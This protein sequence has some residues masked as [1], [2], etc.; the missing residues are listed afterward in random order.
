MI[1]IGLLGFGTV[2][3]GFYDIINKK[4]SDIPSIIGDDLEVVK[5]LVR[6]LEKNRR[7]QI[8]KEK[9][10]LSFEELVNDPR[11]SIIVEVT[12][13]IE[14]SY[15][16]IKEALNNGKHV[17]T[18]NKGVVSAYFEELSSIALNKGLYFLY[19]ASV[20]GGIPVIKPIKDMVKLN[21]I[22]NVM[23]ILNG[24][25][26]YMLTKMTEESLSYNEV[27]NEA[28]SL[29]YAEEDPSSDVEGLDTLR[30]LRILSSIAF[31]GVITEDDIICDGIENI[32]DLD[33]KL[34][35]D[36][37]K[38][39]K[40][41][42]KTYRFKDGYCSIVQPK[43]VDR[44]SFF[45]NVNYAFNSI[46]IEGDNIGDIKFYGLGAGMYPSANAIF[47][48]CIDVV[49][50]N[51]TKDT[52]LRINRLKNYNEEIM[53]EYYVRIHDCDEEIFNDIV[54][55]KLNKDPLCF[56]SKGVK[57]MELLNRIASIQYRDYSIISI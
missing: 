15:E 57:L 30:K 1:G 22:D 54:S 41:I 8:P 48:D 18:A 49:L 13:D 32:S 17:V 38:V 51:Q 26:N 5:V 34:L 28:Q 6:D 24:T 2:G 7:I 21:D 10:T 56:I 16:Y 40:L 35:K 14:K 53:G 45:S 55:E 42:A 27:L 4:R 11:I 31:G 12:S 29:G 39:V 9:L 33:I 20:G 46:S 47:T 37:G 44:G 50:N 3:Q 25:C 43:A 52:P 23:G 19:E 36:K